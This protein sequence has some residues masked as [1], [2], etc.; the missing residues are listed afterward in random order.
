MHVCEVPSGEPPRAQSVYERD[1]LG[2]ASC[3]RERLAGELRLPLVVPN[4]VEL[5]RQQAEQLDGQH[6][7]VAR[8]P[9]ERALEELDQELVDEPL[10]GPPGAETRTTEAQRR[11][12]EPL[13]VTELAGE[14]R[15][16]QEDLAGTPR[17]R[18]YATPPRR[19]HKGA[20]SDEQHRARARHRAH[21]APS[22]SG[23]WRPRMRATALPGSLPAPR[24]QWPARDAPRADAWK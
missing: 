7:I 11:S 9:L 17:H 13:R 16:L 2:E 15:S 6:R 12:R 5:L 14:L 22:R 4:E 21:R 8:K 24:T 23:D 3:H 1:W 19:W 20:R 10:L 18:W